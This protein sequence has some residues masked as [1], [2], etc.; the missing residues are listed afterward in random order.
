MKIEKYLD[1]TEYG[2]ERTLREC[3]AAGWKIKHQ[4]LTLII[5]EM[6]Y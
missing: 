1:L 6:E 2:I 3:L 5:L 4:G